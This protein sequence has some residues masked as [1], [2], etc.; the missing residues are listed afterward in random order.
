ME[1]EWYKLLYTLLK[2]G[3]AWVSIY[4]HSQN[5]I[6]LEMKLTVM[7]VNITVTLKTV[8]N[9]ISLDTQLCFSEYSH[10][11]GVKFHQKHRELQCSFTYIK[12]VAQSSVWYEWNHT[13]TEGAFEWNSKSIIGENLIYQAIQTWLFST[14]C[15]ICIFLS[16]H[17]FHIKAWHFQTV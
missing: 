6:I 17:K 3:L 2:T 7:T 1:R 14:I 10:V 9:W 4:I 11:M 12:H 8:S 16:V 5:I 15:C 13:V